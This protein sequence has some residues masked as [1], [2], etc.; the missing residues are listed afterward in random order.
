[1]NLRVFIGATVEWVEEESYFFRLSKWTEPLLAFYDQNPDFISPRGR[2]NEVV[3][4]PQ[5]HIQFSIHT[6]HYKNFRILRRLASW[7]RRA[8]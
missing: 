6:V 1:M 4:S 2:R 3:H 7:A 5:Q 8:G